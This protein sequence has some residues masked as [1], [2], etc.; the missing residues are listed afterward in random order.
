MP[1]VTET[2]TELDFAPGTSV[3]ERTTLGLATSL[4]STECRS[5]EGR[6]AGGQG[7]VWAQP[8]KGRPATQLQLLGF[9]QNVS[10]LRPELNSPQESQNIWILGETT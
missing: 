6:A 4:V 1:K 10:P 3:P 2:R 9:R 8:P 7:M 5:P